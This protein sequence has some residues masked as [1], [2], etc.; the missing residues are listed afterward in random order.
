[1][2]LIFSHFEHCI[3]VVRAQHPDM[4]RQPV[5]L[6]RLAHHVFRALHERLDRF[7]ATHDLSTSAWAVLMMIY[8]SPNR[9]ITPS[10]I[11][12]AVVQSRTHM[13]RVADD[14]VAAGLI[15]RS[16]DAVDRRRIEL[17]LTEQGAERIKQVLPLAWA[18][19]QTTLAIFSADETAVLE[20]LLRRWLGH[21]ENKDRPTCKTMLALDPTRRRIGSRIRRESK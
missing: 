15:E 14:L 18:E 8:S 20:T 11:S 4:P 3:D 10:E 21:L 9:A 16:H 17:R 13:T 6:M 1:M 5:V 19:Y 12:A 7:F 2:A